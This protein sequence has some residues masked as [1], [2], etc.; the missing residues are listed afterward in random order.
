MREFI[1]TKRHHLTSW[2]LLM[3]HRVVEKRVKRRRQGRPIENRHYAG[4]DLSEMGSASLL[5]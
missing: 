2:A 5:G 1:L 4:E 3:A